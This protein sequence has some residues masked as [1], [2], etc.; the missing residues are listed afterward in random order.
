MERNGRESIYRDRNAVQT[1]PATSQ[2]QLYEIVAIKGCV[3]NMVTVAWLINPTGAAD[4]V[5]VTDELVEHW[6]PG[7]LTGSIASAGI[8]SNRRVFAKTHGKRMSRAC[9]GTLEPIGAAHSWQREL[10]CA[11]QHPGQSTW[12]SDAG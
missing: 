9:A 2:T 1:K 12:T 6:F 7:L 8:T 10:H 11:A 5:F 4:L 3:T